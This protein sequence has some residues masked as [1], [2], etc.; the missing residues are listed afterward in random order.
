MP[1]KSAGQPR[2]N[3][4]ATREAEPW[5]PGHLRRAHRSNDSLVRQ[6]ETPRQ[7]FRQTD[8]RP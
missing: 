1:V 4:P 8:R 7:L 5:R 2:E 6:N 3:I